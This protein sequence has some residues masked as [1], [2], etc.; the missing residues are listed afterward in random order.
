MPC[1]AVASQDVLWAMPVVPHNAFRVQAPPLAQ[2]ISYS[3][4]DILIGDGWRK[5]LWRP[6]WRTG[7]CRCSK[8]A[9]KAPP[10]CGWRLLTWKHFR[11]QVRRIVLYYHLDD[12]SCHVVEQKQD[13]SG[14]PQGGAWVIDVLDMSLELTGGCSE[15]L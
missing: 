4:V 5:L 14:M 13:N 15:T 2:K 8:R 12:D 3:S 11:L 6:T 7:G 10:W 1:A 9:P